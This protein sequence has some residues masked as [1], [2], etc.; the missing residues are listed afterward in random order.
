M[1]LSTLLCCHICHHFV[2]QRRCSQCRM[3]VCNCKSVNKSAALLSG[4]IRVRLEL[5][6]PEAGPPSAMTA[7]E[8]L[9]SVASTML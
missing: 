8:V 3:I 1:Q 5:W 6:L 2:P 4:D 9:E 7:P